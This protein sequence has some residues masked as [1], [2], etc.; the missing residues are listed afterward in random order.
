MEQKEFY[1][2]HATAIENLDSIIKN[3]IKANELGEIFL[4]EDREVGGPAILAA[5]WQ[6]PYVRR[7]GDNMIF[8]VGDSIARNQ[9]FIPGEEYVNFF[10]PAEAINGEL[11]HDNVA[12]LTA[13]YQWIARQSVIYPSAYE[14][15]TVGQKTKPNSVT[16]IKQRRV[17]H[18]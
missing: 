16:P 1:Y 12:E 9:I 10:I 11:E 4:Y 6:I 14:I 15:R 7:D 5:V 13:R 2:C 8:Y 17:G 3:G 18:E